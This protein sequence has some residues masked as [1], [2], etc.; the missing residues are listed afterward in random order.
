MQTPDAAEETKL[1][2]AYKRE[3]AKLGELVDK[4][5]R[6]HPWKVLG[7]T[8]LVGVVLGLLVGRRS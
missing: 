4:V 7:V 6:E 5:V 1:I 2:D 8:A 3:L